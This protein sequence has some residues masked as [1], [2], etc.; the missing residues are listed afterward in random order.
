MK[1]QIR[2]GAFINATGW[3]DLGAS[4][5]GQAAPSVEAPRIPKSAELFDQPMGR[6]GRFDDYTRLGCAAVALSLRQAG[7]DKAAE[8]R[9]IGLVSASPHG[10][11]ATD[12]RFQETTREAGGLLSSPNLF[13]YTLPGV[14]HGECAVHF[15][16]TGPTLALGD[17]PRGS[18]D[19]A[20]LGMNALEIA[21]LLLESGK[22]EAILV[23]WLDSPPGADAKLEL[24]GPLLQGAV[25][26]L[27]EAARGEGDGTVATASGTPSHLDQVTAHS[28]QS[29]QTPENAPRPEQGKAV[30]LDFDQGVLR[31]ADGRDVLSVLDLFEQ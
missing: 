28:I 22:C 30:V 23:G 18:G 29:A 19:C 9:A 11:M 12:L 27:V 14:M 2:A 6:Y 4:A 13:S 16:L 5:P 15:K 7:L 25:F 21:A 20:G 3:G 17:R 1:I 31:R 10:C 24:D 8:K 26:V